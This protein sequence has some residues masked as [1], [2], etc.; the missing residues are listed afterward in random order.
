MESLDLCSSWNRAIAGSGSVA[1]WRL[2]HSNC[3]HFL[4][5]M[6]GDISKGAV[7]LSLSE[8][9]F[10]VSPFLNPEGAET[11]FLKDDVYSV[12]EIDDLLC[13]D[14]NFRYHANDSFRSVASGSRNHFLEMVDNSVEAIAGGAFDKVV[15]SFTNAV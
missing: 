10:V 4:A 13:D 15:P 11:L 1:L 9:G 6:S 3:I 2:P 7:D 12:F 5:D 14:S 8:F